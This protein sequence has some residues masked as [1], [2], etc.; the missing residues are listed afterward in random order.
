[1]VMEDAKSKMRPS[2][3]FIF[4]QMEAEGGAESGSRGEGERPNLS[5]YN[6]SISSLHNPFLCVWGVQGEDTG[7]LMRAELSAQSTEKG[8]L[9][10]FSITEPYT[11]PY[12]SRLPIPHIQDQVFNA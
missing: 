10:R 12:R 5:Y 6:N 7:S 3:C 9:D 1:M 11:S 4:G 8:T 2:G